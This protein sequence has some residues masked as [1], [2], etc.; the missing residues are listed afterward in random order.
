MRLKCFYFSFIFFALIFNVSCAG[1]YITEPVS[2]HKHAALGIKN[3]R[4]IVSPQLNFQPKKPSEW[5]LSNGLRV[6]FEPDKIVPMVRGTLYVPGGSV[7]EPAEL[8]G[9]AGATGQ[10]MREG[11]IEW[12]PP[13]VLDKRLDGLAASIES[14]YGEQYGSVSFSCLTEN[15][16]EILQVFAGVVQRP[17]FDSERLGLWKK[18]ALEGIARRPDDPEILSSMIFSAVLYG[19][20]SPYNRVE[21]PETIQRITAAEM[22]KFYRKFVRPNGAILV[23]SG[24]VESDF[25]K[26]LI[27]MHFGSWSSSN[28]AL[29]PLPEMKEEFRPG[30]FVLKRKF[31]QSTVLLG[32]VGPPRVFPEMYAISV[33]NRLFGMGGLESKLFSEVRTKEGLAYSIYGGVFPGVKLGNFQVSMGTKR[34]E[35]PRAIAKVIDLTE[36]AI[37]LPPDPKEIGYAQ[38]GVNRGFVFKF[39]TPELVAQRAAIIDL[40]GYPKDFDSNYLAKIRDVSSANILESVNKWVHPDKLSIVVVGDVEAN[41]IAKNIGRQMPVYEVQ[42]DIM[43]HIRWSVN[44]SEKELR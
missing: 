26:D 43:P 27:Q 8:A 42:F 13:S 23:V 38:E 31:D 36:Q 35:T 34:S 5:Q 32:H 20:N 18:L 19:D 1:F 24:D 44:G 16:P 39:A 22:R 2:E 30:I 11:G 40:L 10:Q 6:M 28:E 21:T 33:F 7:F 3:G 41:E 15:L 12:M 37:K 14:N 9:L 4:E 29:S 25:L 17:R